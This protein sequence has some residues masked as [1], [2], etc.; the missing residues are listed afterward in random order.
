MD[1]AEAI[2]RLTAL[3]GCDL[4]QLAND[5]GITVWK[6]DKK[7]KG[8]AGHVIERCLGLP[9]NSS[10]APNFGSWELKVFPVA[11]R[12]GALH[13]KETI[14]ITMIDP[15]EVLAKP[16]AKSHLFNKLHKMLVVGRIWESVAEDRSILYSVGEFDLSNPA[17]YR[18]CEEDYNL[19][20][21]TIAEHGFSAL[22]GKMGLL[23]QPRTKG[24]GHGST[25]RAFYARAKFVNQIAQLQQ[26]DKGLWAR[27]NDGAWS[28]LLTDGRS[29]ICGFGQETLPPD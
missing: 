1:R 25:S 9:I 16:F 4:R 7:N 10:R 8:W 6:D 11:D 23:I 20:R 21:S 27:D 26:P 5:F 29:W 22:S 2:S 13:V 3:V 28:Y 17:V 19:V 14:A 15:V 18:Q 12:R 24:A